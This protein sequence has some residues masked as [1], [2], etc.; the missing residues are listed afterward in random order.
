MKVRFDVYF[1]TKYLNELVSESF[2]FLFGNEIS[3][4][5]RLCWSYLLTNKASG[6]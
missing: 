6:D 2:L 1:F 4:F 5:Y 3:R